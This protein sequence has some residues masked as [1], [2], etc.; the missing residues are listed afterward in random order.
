MSKVIQLK[1]YLP[2]FKRNWAYRNWGDVFSLNGL[3]LSDE[4]AHEFVDRAIAEGY[5]YDVDVPDEKV[6]EW[7]G[8][9]NEGAKHGQRKTRDNRG[10]SV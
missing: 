5:K 1:T 7:L 10:H 2:V 6:C 4:L 8:L 9:N 3:P